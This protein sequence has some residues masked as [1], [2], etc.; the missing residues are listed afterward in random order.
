M[1]KKNTDTF[2]SADFI[3]QI[4]SICSGA[5]PPKILDEF[6]SLFESKISPGAAYFENNLLRIIHASLNPVS[7]IYDIVRYPQ[8]SDVLLLV[9]LNSNYL[10]GI[11]CR[12][13]EYFYWITGNDMLQIPVTEQ[14]VAKEVHILLARY[15]S[16][17]SKILLLKKLKQRYMLRIGVRDFSGIAT[18]EQTTHELSALAKVITESLFVLCLE[19]TLAKYGIKKIIVKYSLCALGKMGGGE[20]NYSSD[21]DLILFYERNRKTKS[22]FSYQEI[23]SSAIKLFIERASVP[24]ENGILYRID[25]RLRPDGRNAPLCGSLSDYLRYY[26]TRGEQWERQMLIKASLVAGSL[27]LFKKF[28]NYLS[29]F[30]YPATFYSSPLEQIARL[31]KSSVAVKG[32]ENNIKESSGGLRDIEFPVQA[33]QLLNGGQN[34]MI[35]TGNT[36]HAINLLEQYNALNKDEAE[37]FR[38]NYIFYRRIEHFLQ[39]MD[40][41]QT[42][43][44]PE[45]GEVTEKLAYYLGFNDVSSLFEN[46]KIRKAE[47]KKVA[48]SI[49]G[50]ENY[51]VGQVNVESVGFVNSTTAMKNFLFLR[52]GKGL[53][54][55]KEF[56]KKTIELF[57]AIEEGILTGL[58]SVPNPDTTLSNFVRIIK[59]APL[60]ELW[61]ELLSSPHLLKAFL[62]ICS[63]SRKAVDLMA[64][65]VELHELFLSGE[66]FDIASAEQ[67]S[68]YNSKAILFILSVQLT[69]GLIDYTT[70]GELIQN[71]FVFKL[72]R[73]IENWFLQYNALEFCVAGLGSFGSGDMN[74]ASDI[75]L[76][77]IGRNIPPAENVQDDFFKL[78]RQL[79]EKIE[80]VNIDSRL[81]PEGKSST[82]IWDIQ[83]FSEYLSTRARVWEFQ[84]YSKLRFITGSEKLFDEIVKA[85]KNSVSRLSRQLIT[86]ELIAMKKKI[87]PFMQ[88]FTIKRSAG[89]L[90]DIEFL[91]QFLI[92]CTPEIFEICRSLRLS[93]IP[94]ILCEKGLITKEE[95]E[96]L[97]HNIEWLFTLNLHIQNSLQVNNGVLPKLTDIKT[98]YG[99]GMLA[100]K[101]FERELNEIISSNKKLFVKYVR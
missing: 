30:I 61:Y 77:I 97:R 40:D 64:E 36:L 35:R 59:S 7:L 65:D 53:L 50:S 76:L 69:L 5:V 81:R 3:A 29:H 23:F 87:T 41:R 44:I 19:E 31:R 43:T 82:I 63:S 55:R 16:T 47:V 28:I 100:K 46:I 68:M 67:L 51:S 27:R 57:S 22:N 54:G 60:P 83:N 45:S 24:D 20:L 15:K 73:E 21:I 91:M 93:N 80:P 9:A 52:E 11:L 79:K 33:L 49:L 42:H 2:F 38:R 66:V 1:S 96:L 88:A 58:Q 71:T 48:S 25:F 72:R 101:E 26:E 95:A 39:L 89:G 99:G 6:F 34:P 62:S 70:V 12:H 8:F 56:N 78:F 14:E 13:P 90:S 17:D 37:I 32:T 10:T 18:L 98:V 75:D 4:V 92:L 84:A 94:Q 85:I 86:S 74:F